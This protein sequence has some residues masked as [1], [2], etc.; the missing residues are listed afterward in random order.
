M[1]TDTVFRKF[2]EYIQGQTDS[3]QASLEDKVRRATTS[4]TERDK[5][6]VSE[7]SMNSQLQLRSDDSQEFE[8]LTYRLVG[9]VEKDRCSES[10]MKSVRD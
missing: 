3:I 1:A 5:S 2:R 9:A 8:D 10:F 6:D 7:K 4:E